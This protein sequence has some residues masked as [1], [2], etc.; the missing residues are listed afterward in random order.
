MRKEPNSEEPSSVSTQAK[1]KPKMSNQMFQHHGKKGHI[2]RHHVKK[3]HHG[4]QP[5]FVSHA[6]AKPKMSNQM[7]QHVGKHRDKKGHLGKPHGKKKINHTR[8]NPQP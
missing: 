5:T 1:P 7:S 4:K 6:K 3:E 2:G 8:E